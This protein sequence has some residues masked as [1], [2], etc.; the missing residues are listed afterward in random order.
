MA[1]KKHHNLISKEEYKIVLDDLK[2]PEN[3]LNDNVINMFAEL[4]ERSL[5]HAYADATWII[6]N[7]F[8]LPKMLSIM[9]EKKE[10]G[11]LL[12]KM[13]RWISK[14]R[15]TRVDTIY[16]PVNVNGNH[17]VL[18]VVSVKYGCMYVCDSMGDE[19]RYMDNVIHMF[20]LMYKKDFIYA[21]FLK[22]VLKQKNGYDCGVY[23]IEFLSRMMDKQDLSANKMKWSR[24]LLINTFNI[25]R[26]NLV[27][28]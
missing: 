4:Q 12:D 13:Q 7:T 21:K 26:Q 23:T 5:G 6:L 3:Y 28:I 19:I 16:I 1:E 10:D 9:A 20:K 15:R 2:S 18:Y 25:N 14:Y 17:W 8:F 24:K 11:V 27:R 22:P